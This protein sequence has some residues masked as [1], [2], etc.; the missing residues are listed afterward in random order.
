MET[1]LAVLIVEDSESDAQL[2]LR[3]L[4]KAGYGVVWQRVETDEQMRAALGERIWDIVISDYSLPQF[5]GPAALEVL[6]QTQPN[7]PFI[8]VSGT[9]GEENAVALMKSGAQDYLLKDNLTRLIP[10]VQRELDQAAIRCERKKTE[11]ALQESEEKYRMLVEQASDAIF[12]ANPDGQYVDVN[13]AGCKLSGYTRDEILQ[14]RMQDIAGGILEKPLRFTELEVGKGLITER[15]MICKGGRVIWTEISACKLPNGNLQGIVRDITKRKQA[16]KELRLKSEEL[17][18]ILDAIPA[19]VWIGMDPECKVITGNRYVNEL[20]GVAPGTNLSQTASEGQ[21]ASPVKYL[22]SD[23]TEYKVDELPIQRAVALARELPNQEFVYV[24]PNGQQIFVFGNA[25]PLFDDNGDVRGVI[26]AFWDITER[27]RTEDKLRQLSSAVEHSP[28]A[29][30]ITDINGNIEYVNPK[31]TELTGYTFAEVLGGNPRILKSD[32][33][34]PEVYAELWQTILAGR[35]WRGEFLNRKKNGELFWE[36]ASIS[37]IVDSSG[38]IK[39]FVAVNE[40][41]TSRKEAEAKITRLNAGLEQLAMTDYLT[42]LYNR[43]YFMQRGTEEFKRASRTRQP[44]SLLMID[45]DHFKK[46]N[47]THGHE[48]GDM[49][50]QQV[51]A[52]LKSG[53]RETDILGRM[54]GEEFA[55]LLPDTSLKEAGFLAD[56]IRQLVGNAPLELSLKS[57]VVTISIGVVMITDEM[58]GID[59]MLRNADLAMYKAKRFGGNCMMQYDDISNSDQSTLILTDE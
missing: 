51:A 41:I 11:Q 29:I 34:P 31:F 49:V 15:E 6:K 9:I 46:V 57:L 18:T 53:L 45:I 42:S 4:K 13:F 36:Y 8:V 27:K 54:G 23:G 58:T 26:G 5:D 3:L 32:G 48:A 44:L 38:K 22:K 47:D 21:K 19:F 28:S 40:D 50:L 43:R 37:A 14:L 24:L 10:A 16:E 25:V 1:P 52:A 39:H 17:K 30:M 59:H 2:L 7:T 20:F 35:E 55:V 12:V 56:R 33:T